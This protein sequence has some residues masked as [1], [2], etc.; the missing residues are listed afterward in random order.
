MNPRTII[1]LLAKALV[2]ALLLAAPATAHAQSG[3]GD[4]FDYSINPGNTKTITITNYTGANSVVSIPTNIN[5]LTVSGIGNGVD[6]VFSSSLTSITIPDSVT[7]IAA[8]AF[9]FCSSLTNVTIGKGV[10][11]IGS[12]AFELCT[13]LS[14]ITIPNGVTSIGSFA[15]DDCFKMTNV[16][17]AQSVTNIG[18]DAFQGFNG[19]TGFYFAGNAPANFSIL[20]FEESEDWTVY[21]LPDTTGWG[22]T[23]VPATL[24]NPRIQTSG[25]GFGIS[26]NQFGFNITATNKFTVVVEACTNLANPAWTPLQTLTLT[27]GSA[28]F[29]DPTWTNYFARYYGLGYP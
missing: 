5:S 16:T 9:S 28:Y 27:N 21:Y 8:L 2:V 22:D 6:S 4:D 3:S 29:S 26:N 15:F 1:S 24:W 13:S 20:L 25:S 17:I 18:D 7:S 14:S 12:P 19:P 11:N 10:T 23:G